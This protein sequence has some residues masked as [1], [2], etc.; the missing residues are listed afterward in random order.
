MASTDGVSVGPLLDSSC[1]HMVSGA[2]F[3]MA[4]ILLI[5]ALPSDLITSQKTC[6]L[7]HHPGA[8]LSTYEFGGW[9][10]LVHSLWFKN[11]KVTFGTDGG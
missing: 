4:L 6:L 10:H 3:I 9:K 11:N 5:G 8:K 1:L 7:C 2:F